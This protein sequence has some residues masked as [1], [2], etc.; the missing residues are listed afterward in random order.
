[1]SEYRR[2]N[3]PD[4]RTA[5]GRKFFWDSWYDREP[6]EPFDAESLSH[7]NNFD[8]STGRPIN[9][10]E[11]IMMPS[12]TYFRLEQ[13]SKDPDHDIDEYQQIL[14]D[15]VHQHMKYLGKHRAFE[16]RYR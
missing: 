12:D 4:R 9:W 2:E 8:P 7:P 3:M 15:L 14:D 10:L 16:S 5:T 11:Q 1:M 13:M 6:K